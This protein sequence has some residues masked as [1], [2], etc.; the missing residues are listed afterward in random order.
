MYT[1]CRSSLLS[2]LALTLPA[3][4][5]GYA[6]EGQAGMLRYPDVSQAQIVFVYANDLWLVDRAGGL[7]T[8]LASPAGAER[9]PRF[10]ADGKTIAFSG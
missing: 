4:S 5:P 2:L 1:R 7:A 10:S 6:Q 9:N 3:A 8:P